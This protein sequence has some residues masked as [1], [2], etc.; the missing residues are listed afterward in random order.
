MSIMNYYE[1]STVIGMVT[2]CSLIFAQTDWNL[3]DL[4]IHSSLMPT[5]NT[6]FDGANALVPSKKKSSWT[7]IIFEDLFARA[8]RI[9]VFHLSTFLLLV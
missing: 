3:L 5:G 4:Q 9:L 1:L 2:L 8:L 6:F 7:F